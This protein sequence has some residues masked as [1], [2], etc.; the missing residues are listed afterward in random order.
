MSDQYQNAENYMTYDQPQQQDEGYGQYAAAPSNYTAAP[1]NYVAQSANYSTQ[2]PNY[3]QNQ[4]IQQQPQAYYDC[5]ETPCYNMAGQ[6][7][8]E[9]CDQ[10]Y[11][12]DQ[13]DCM[14]CE[15]SNVQAGGDSCRPCTDNCPLPMCS[16]YRKLRYVQPPRRQ[17]FKPVSLYRR[18]SIPMAT[19]TIY[20]KS[21]E[22]VDPN[23]ANCCRMPP[24]N[25]SGFLR[26][27]KGPFP[28]ETVTKMSFQPFCGVERTKPIFP[29]SR[30]LLGKGPMQGLTTQKHD[31]VP[32]F[33]FRRSKIAPR[34]NISK[35]C[36]CI[37]KSTIQRLSFIPPCGVSRTPSCRPVANYK[38]PEGNFNFFKEFFKFEL[39]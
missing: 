9:Y 4:Q 3:A 39:F 25:P 37:E 23:T 31:F 19:E 35:S 22:G 10:N 26:T 1:T 16:P 2:P 7:C 5:P 38:K 11:Q 24:F 21:F 33:Q 18:P 20:R 29:Q 34:D 15:E 30:T 14:D 28:K 12:N 13:S 27:P 36:G 17:S 8:T 32:K 6:D